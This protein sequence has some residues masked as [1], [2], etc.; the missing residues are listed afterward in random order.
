MSASLLCRHSAAALVG[1]SASASRSEALIAVQGEGVVCYS[2][3]SQVCSP[4]HR[5]RVKRLPSAV[6]RRMDS[7]AALGADSSARAER[8]SVTYLT[9]TTHSY[10]FCTTDR[11]AP[12]VGRWDLSS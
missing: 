6:C 12:T 3:E 2:Y 11:G 4:R 8:F 1:A 10:L 9:Q 5:P 7:R